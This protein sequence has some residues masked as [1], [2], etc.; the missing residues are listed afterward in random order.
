MLIKAQ[1]N[2]SF[3]WHV[4]YNIDILIAFLKLN[5]FLGSSLQSSI[6]SDLPYIW[7]QQT[8]SEDDVEVIAEQS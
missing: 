8:Y 7:N 4:L 5:I 2:S 3:R 1:H 6:V